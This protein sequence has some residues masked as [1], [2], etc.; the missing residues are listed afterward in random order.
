[1]RILARV[2]TKSGL[3]WFHFDH[4][5][6]RHATTIGVNAG[7]HEGRYQASVDAGR[8]LLRTELFK[9]LVTQPWVAFAA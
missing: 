8:P 5:Q 7:N 6:F 3:N 4:F 2:R 1:M 9:A